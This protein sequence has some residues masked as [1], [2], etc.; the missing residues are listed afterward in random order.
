MEEIN[1]STNASPRSDMPDTTSR[2]DASANSQNYTEDRSIDRVAEEKEA[3]EGQAR[4][5]TLLGQQR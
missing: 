1:L 5:L 4:W 3:K 2:D